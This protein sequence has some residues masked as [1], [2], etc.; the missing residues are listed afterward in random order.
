M[1]SESNENFQAQ[2]MFSE[3][4]PGQRLHPGRWS[5]VYRHGWFGLQ[6]LAL[7]LNLDNVLFVFF[8]LIEIF[9]IK[10]MQISEFS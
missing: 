7:H 5:L 1:F 6:V 2:W 3:R 8:F 4:E 10:K 9:N